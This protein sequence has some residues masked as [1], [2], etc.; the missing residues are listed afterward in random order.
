[1]ENRVDF[2][3]GQPILDLILVAGKNRADIAL[4]EANQIAVGPTIVLTSQMQGRF[5]VREGNQRLNAIFSQL[6]KEIVV[7]LQ[8]SFIGLRL[9]S[10]WENPRPG[11]GSPVDLEA[12]LSK[13]SNVLLIAMIE[14][15]PFQLEIIWCRP[16]GN[17]RIAVT[18]LGWHSAFWSHILN[19]QAFS[20]QIIG[21][22]ILV[23]CS[24]TAP[25]EIL[26]KFT[27]LHFLAFVFFIFIL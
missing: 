5:I 15:N 27:H 7:E 8:T 14:I 1:M 26:R 16:L 9:V 12:H 13:E 17:Q 20:I 23:S 2:I 21:A 6:I 10:V 3:K 24:C 4:V 19:R 18:W 22:F 25:E 11:N